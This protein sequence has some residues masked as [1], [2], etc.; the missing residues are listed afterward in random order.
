VAYPL[1]REGESPKVSL[2]LNFVPH[3]L[4]GLLSNK[5]PRGEQRPLC[6]SQLGLVYFPPLSNKRHFLLLMAWKES[7]IK[8]QA[9]SV[10]KR[11]TEPCLLQRPFIMWNGSQHSIVIG[12]YDNKYLQHPSDLCVELQQPLC[13]QYSAKM[14]AE[15]T[16]TPS[17]L[18]FQKPIKSV[19]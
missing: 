17:A 1:K 7:V 12:G 13:G 5:G 19:F 15:K 16:N 14:R 6:E 10:T 18:F 3:S 11:E 9:R 8:I 2:L 4:A